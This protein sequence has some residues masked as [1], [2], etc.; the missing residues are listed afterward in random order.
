MKKYLKNYIQ[1]IE[2]VIKTKKI[3]NSTIEKHLIKIEFFQ[4]ERFIHLLV[5]IF[6]ATLFLIFLGLGIIS[7]IFFLID[8]IV[9][10]FLICY[11]VHYFHLENG[12]QHLY[13][14]YDQMVEQDNS[15]KQN[16]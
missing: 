5:T 13:E 4:H 3:T 9:M 15:K 8:G 11:I 10:I 1:E 7:Y 2:N 6:Y 16:V 14:L 12:V